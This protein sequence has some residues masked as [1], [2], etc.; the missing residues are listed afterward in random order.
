MINGHWSEFG[1]LSNRHIF[2]D[3]P[4]NP[5]NCLDASNIYMLFDY[6]NT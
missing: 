2:S 4:Y 5:H 1:K 3:N 6:R